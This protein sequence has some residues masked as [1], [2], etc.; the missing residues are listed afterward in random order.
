MKIGLLV[1]S[2]ATANPIISKHHLISVLPLHIT[3]AGAFDMLDTTANIKKHQIYERIA[4]G[5]S[6]KT[7]QA[8]PGELAAK[9]DELLKKYDHVVHI[10]IPENLSSM[11]ATA[12][13]VANQDKYHGKVTVI[14][15]RNLPAQGLRELVLRLEDEIATHK[16]KTPQEVVNAYQHYEPKYYVAIIPGDLRNLAQGGRA[17]KIA[18]AVLN[19]F[20]TKVLI[21]WQAHPAKEGISRTV[22]NLADVVL[23]RADQ[24]HRR[25]F[26]LIITAPIN[27]N[28]KNLTMLRE[29]LDNRRI[30]YHI[31]EIPPLYPIH[32]GLNTIG[33][34]VSPKK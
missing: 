14:H 17:T 32:A 21:R 10:P 3:G 6:F 28:Q 26:E 16:L 33:F 31:E 23:K 5:E 25:N 24:L 12:Q 15:N 29:A 27:Y 1:D 4:S 34:I 18:S 13:M 9:Y 22:T 19:V 2:S 20:K 8:S 7:S 30:R 11:L